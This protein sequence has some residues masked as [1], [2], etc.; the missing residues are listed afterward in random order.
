L[1]ASGCRACC[2]STVC[3]A[4]ASPLAQLSS[5]RACSFM[6]VILWCA[7]VPGVL[8]S[9]QLQSVAMWIHFGMSM[10]HVHTG[11]CCCGCMGTHACTDILTLHT[12]HTGLLPCVWGKPACGG[13]GHLR[14]P[15]LAGRRSGC[16]IRFDSTSAVLA[17]TVCI[18]FLHVAGHAVVV[19]ASGFGQLG[20]ALLT[21][22]TTSSHVPRENH[23][24][25]VP[26]IA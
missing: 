7:F 13:H 10:T 22:A 17:I 24:T 16:I 6:S 3:F 25:V 26:R 5:C 9:I 14:W 8:C 11:M 21:D 23:S 15:R 12:P 1:L 18:P 4:S 20:T 19:W 2:C